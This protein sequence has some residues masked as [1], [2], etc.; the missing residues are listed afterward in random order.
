MKVLFD[1]LVFED[2]AFGGVPRYFTEV[3]RHFPS[4]IQAILPIIETSNVYLQAPPFSLPKAKWSYQQFLPCHA[5]RGKH[6]TFKALS[7]LLAPFVESCEIKN[8]K[9][10]HSLV[11]SGDFDILHLTRAHIYGTNWLSTA[12]KKP[13]VITIHDL[14]PDRLQESER[15]KRERLR[16]IPFVSRFIAVSENTKSDFVS[17]Y[18]VDPDL[19]DVI[20]HGP[21][22]EEKNAGLQTNNGHS[23]YLLFVGGRGGYKNFSFFASAVAPWIRE[24]SGMRLVCTGKP[25]SRC[26]QKLLSDLG[27]LSRCD[28]RFFQTEELPSLYANAFAF[29]FPSMY[30][31]FGIPIL[32][33]FQAGCPAILSRSSC[34]PEIAGEAALFFEPNNPSDLVRQLVRLEIEPA[35]RGNLQNAA[36]NRVKSFSWVKASEE[37]VACYRRAVSSFR[38]RH[39][40]SA[41]TPS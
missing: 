27:I 2:V 15:V 22:G 16:L 40:K 6:F 30:E 34:F 7:L 35:L 32:D 14:I 5:F 20:Y 8:R 28:A 33:A 21:S 41:A 31:G 13:I 18:G 11:S 24:H 23:E 4:D 10:F 25:F 37:T 36:H 26:E 38:S 9:R 12:G 17:E 1:N 19:V 29:V 39:N 3:I